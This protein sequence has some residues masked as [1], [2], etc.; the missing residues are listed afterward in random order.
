MNDLRFCSIEL[1]ASDEFKERKT[2]NQERITCENQERHSQ[3]TAF[4]I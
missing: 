1:T 3:K 2:S 4:N